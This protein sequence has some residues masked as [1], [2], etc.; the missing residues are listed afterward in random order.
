MGDPI[1]LR[2]AA[3]SERKATL[4]D[5][6]SKP[7]EFKSLTKTHM[8]ELRHLM[9]PPRPVVDCLEV[10]Y[11]CLHV[12]EVSN[13]LAVLLEGGHLSIDWRCVQ[14]MLAH[15]ETFF[16]SMGDYDIEPLLAHPTVA[17]YVSEVYFKERSLTEDLRMP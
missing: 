3:L 9:R 11:I 1:F 6:S 16:P 12:K 13:E 14:A 5:L 7:T 17:H 10:V 2:L 8:E 4:E 15:F